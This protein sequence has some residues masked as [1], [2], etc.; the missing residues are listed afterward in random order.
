MKLIIPKLSRFDKEKG[1][2][3]PNT[4]SLDLA[5]FIG[6]HI[7]DGHLGYR[8]EKTEYILQL[9]GHLIKDKIYHEKF[10]SC[11]FRKLFNLKIS[12]KITSINVIGYQFCSKGLFFFLK[13][14]F[15]LPVGKKSDLIKIPNIF[16]QDRELLT[17]C[18]R[19]IIDTDFY[20]FSDKRRPEVGAWFA[21]RRLVC[22]LEK[23]F[24]RLGFNPKVYFDR[25]YFD[26]R[27]KKYYNRHKISIRKRTD[28]ENW[29]KNIRT[30]HP[31]K[32]IKYKY[33]KDGIH[34]KDKDIIDNAQILERIAPMLYRP[35]H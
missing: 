31:V 35:N 8:E 32:Y 7:G 3:L 26:K 29:F 22:D 15:N 30:H 21:G 6:I 20:F 14:N 24:K 4:I 1:I 10:T 9:S 2:K 5:E 17:S 11:L 16:F 23:G 28:I 19:G 13:N 25:G 18:L 33:W 27:T 34:L 12:P